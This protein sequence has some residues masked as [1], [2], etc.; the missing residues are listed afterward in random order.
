MSERSEI[1]ERYERVAGQFTQRVRAVPAG[2][3][4]NAAPCE[5]WVARDVVRHLAEWLPGF[6]FEQWGLD[7]PPIPSADDDPVAAWTV[8]DGTIQAALDHPAT[9]GAKRQREHAQCRRRFV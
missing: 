3:W 4:D 1:S 9:A 2:A 7:A 8:V 5:G 6:F